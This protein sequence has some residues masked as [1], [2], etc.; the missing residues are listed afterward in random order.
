M[1]SA[2]RQAALDRISR[3][4]G[5]G[6]VFLGVLVLAGWALDIEVLRCVVP[7]LIS[8]KANT[9]ICFVL[10]GV[11]VALTPE[12]R[13]RWAVRGL[14]IALIALAGVILA[15]YSTRWD[16]GVDEWL[17]RDLGSRARGLPPGRMSYA[18]ALAFAIG[19]MAI[20]LVSW[21]RFILAQYLAFGPVLIAV[22]FLSV[23]LFGEQAVTLSNSYV[24]L[25]IH[26]VVG[27][28]F[29]GAAILSRCVEAG[30]MAVL[31]ADDPGGVALRRVLPL[32]VAAMLGLGFVGALGVRLGL[33][34]FA[35]A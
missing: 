19:G 17:V 26:T 20:L 10:A 18:T 11:A 22:F 25:A 27:L 34:S 2:G 35:V 7:G 14:T 24:T 12:R 15:E 16:P 4:I 5:L 31:A 33:Y 21:R 23:Y 32:S 29:L 28:F 6:L 3:S 9:A 8:M 13:A 30:P 1:I